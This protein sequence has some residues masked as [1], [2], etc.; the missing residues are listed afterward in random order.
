M[1]IILS[2]KIHSKTT[3]RVV[4]SVVLAKKNWGVGPLVIGQVCKYCQNVICRC[5]FTV[6]KGGLNTLPAHIAHHT[7]S[8]KTSNG[9]SWNNRGYFADQLP[10][11]VILRMHLSA[12]NKPCFV[13]LQNDCG[14]LF[15]Q[16]I[17]GRQQ[18]TKFKRSMSQNL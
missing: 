14:L 17:P 6:L 16:H 13:A 18:F 1:F 12:E 9:T 3:C 15:L 4:C 2:L 7:P 10:T 8:I 11:Y 5:E